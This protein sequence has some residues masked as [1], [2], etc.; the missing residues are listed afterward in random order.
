MA[1]NWR[2]RHPRPKLNKTLI[3]LDV[4]KKTTMICNIILFNV[5]YNS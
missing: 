2:E 4:V 3:L 1:V 5:L